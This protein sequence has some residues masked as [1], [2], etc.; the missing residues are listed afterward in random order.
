[1][2]PVTYQTFSNERTISNAPSKTQDNKILHYILSILCCCCGVQATEKKDREVYVYEQEGILEPI[3]ML[4]KAITIANKQ[5]LQ[6]GLEVSFV[7]PFQ[8][9]VAE[10][11]YL[12]TLFNGQSEERID[13]IHTKNLND[14]F[15]DID[16]LAREINAKVI[17]H[18]DAKKNC[19]HFLITQ[20]GCKIDRRE[21][22]KLTIHNGYLNYDHKFVMYKG[23]QLLANQFHSHTVIKATLNDG[24]VELS[25]DYDS[26][27]A[28]GKKGFFFNVIEE[29]I[30]FMQL[31]H[32]R[33]A[34]AP[35]T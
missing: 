33:E 30:K 23:R 12:L 19:Q 25:D 7:D 10:P 27:R 11:E 4:T 21:V 1:M 18:L 17:Q 34:A 35:Q 22:K 3:T 13:I 28:D 32:T 8:S 14:S 9:K 16:Q 24:V 31:Y 5:L 29:D 2:Q 26:M 6:K 20:D 15:K